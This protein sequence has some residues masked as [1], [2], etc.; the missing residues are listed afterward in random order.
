MDAIWGLDYDF[1]TDKCFFRPSCPECEEPLWKDEKGK[2]ICV[3]CGKEISVTQKEMI[4]WLKKREEQKIVYEDCHKSKYF[5]CDGKKCVRTLYVRNKV[6]L[7][8]QAAS[9]YCEK[10][11]MHF[12]V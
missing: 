12:I 10:C 5:G 1:H 2:Y 7:E 6:T 9:G 8:W 11:G 4:D 3:E